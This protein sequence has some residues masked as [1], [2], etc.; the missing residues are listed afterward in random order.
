[1][2]LGMSCGEHL[3]ELNPAP[4]EEAVCPMS[5]RHRGGHRGVRLIP[6]SLTVP[7]SNHLIAG[8]IIGR[9]DCPALYTC[10]CN[11]FSNW[12]D[13]W[14]DWF[15]YTDFCSLEIGGAFLLKLWLVP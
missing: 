11:Y 14:H 3:F 13:K 5:S 9:K 7:A 8:H 10:V 4:R 12:G 1:M 2:G 6:H 15:L